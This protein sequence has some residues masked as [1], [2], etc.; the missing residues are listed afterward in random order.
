M[1]YLCTNKEN[2]ILKIKSLV[3]TENGDILVNCGEVDFSESWLKDCK[4]IMCTINF[5]IDKEAAINQV[6]TKLI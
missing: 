2:A 3:K 5:S 4:K 6:L 1:G